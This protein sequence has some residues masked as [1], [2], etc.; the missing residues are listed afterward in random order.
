MILAGKLSG[1][2]AAVTAYEYQRKVLNKMLDGKKQ[3]AEAED[4]HVKISNLD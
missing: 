4:V 1:S 2:N 3:I